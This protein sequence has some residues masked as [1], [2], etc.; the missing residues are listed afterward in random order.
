MI[1]PAGK[2]LTGLRESDAPSFLDAAP[3]SRDR[4]LSLNIVPF[5]AEVNVSVEVV[6]GPE[7]VRV[8][9]VSRV[10]GNDCRDLGIFSSR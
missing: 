10:R 8:S 1:N 3:N 4:P 6:G 9:R 7:V 5:G 2:Q